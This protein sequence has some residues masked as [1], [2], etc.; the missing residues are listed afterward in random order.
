MAAWGL[1]GFYLWLTSGGE[2]AT[3]ARQRAIRDIPG[4]GTMLLTSPPHDPQGNGVGERAVNACMGI[5]RRMAIGF[6]ARINC[7]IDANHPLV[8]WMPERTGF[9]LNLF[10]PGSQDGFTVFRKTVG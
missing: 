9:V 5:L 2:P 3:R 8:Q 1:P 6:Y 7:R 4:R 10:L